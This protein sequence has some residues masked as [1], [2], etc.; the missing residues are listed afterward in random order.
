MRRTCGAAIT[1]RS[2]LPWGLEAA[3]RPSMRRWKSIPGTRTQCWVP[4]SR[5]YSCRSTGRCHHMDAIPNARALSQRVLDEDPHNAR[6][7]AVLGVISM[8]FDWNWLTAE[9]FLREAVTLNP[10]DATAQQW[11]GELY[12]HQSRFDECRRQLRIALELDPLSPVLLMQQGTPASIPEISILQSQPT[13]VRRRTPLS[14]LSDDT[15][16]GLREL[17]WA[18]G[19]RRYP[20]TGNRCRTSV[21]RLSEVP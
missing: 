10:N 15:Y 19:T 2:D 17:V 5:G 14:L 7:R 1:G 6:A 16:S 20:P 12:C 21:W 9:S 3:S 18:T 13:R 4:P 11:L 8:Q